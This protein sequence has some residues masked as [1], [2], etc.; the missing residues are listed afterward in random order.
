ML[1]CTNPDAELSYLTVIRPAVVYMSATFW[2]RYLLASWHDEAG[3]R[4]GEACR[5][6]SQ[7]ES[8]DGF[9]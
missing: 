5:I 1:W 6:Q 4:Y 7:E 2:L 9:T 8:T 3:E